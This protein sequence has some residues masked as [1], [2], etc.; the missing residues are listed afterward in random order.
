MQLADPEIASN[1]EAYMKISRE[2][3]ALTPT[4]ECFDNY[5]AT[6]QGI[7]DA[8]EMIKDAAGDSEMLDMLR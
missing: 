8:K 3:A 4:I 5:N 1:P 7:E 2:S 6:I